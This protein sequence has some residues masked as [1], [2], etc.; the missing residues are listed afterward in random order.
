M[1][2]PADKSEGEGREL[3][4]KLLERGL[5]AYGQGALAQA[6]SDW[7]RALEL[8]PGNERIREYA[9]YV[10]D[11]FTG[12]D[13][14]F[15]AARRAEEEA[16][17]AGVPLGQ[18]DLPGDA[19]DEIEIARVAPTPPPRGTPQAA[20][21]I[22]REMLAGAADL[23]PLDPGLYDGYF[24]KLN[25]HKPGD[26]YQLV[27]GEVERPL[28][29]AVLEFTKGNQSEAASDNCTGPLAVPSRR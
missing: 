20:L 12:L 10:R 9:Q 3:A 24:R 28:F 18:A 16:A 17:R 21:G 15:K 27:L 26:L 13:R 25:G 1:A 19:Y 22:A 29:R 2:D 8:D 6:L 7:D 14:A 5:A 23:D 11:N 4:Q